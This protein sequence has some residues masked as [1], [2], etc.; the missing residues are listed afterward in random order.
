[1][2]RKTADPAL[3]NQTIGVLSDAVMQLKKVLELP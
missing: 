1:M 3:I 2:N